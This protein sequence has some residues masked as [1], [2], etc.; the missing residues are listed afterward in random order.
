MLLFNPKI[1][2]WDAGFQLSFLS[3]IG[4]IYLS[5]LI[6]KD[7][8]WL[9]EFFSLRDNLVS[10]ISAIIITLP[11][12]LFNFG[13]LSIVAPI[14]N[15][16]ILPAIPLIMFLGFWQMFFA[17]FSVFLSG[18]MGWG[19]WLFLTYVIKVVEIFSSLSFAAVDSQIS[20]WMMFILYVLI[21]IFTIKISRKAK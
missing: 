9:P 18:I 6:K 21:I 5:P 4:L 10:T 1:L 13:R 14:V 11:L 12:I 3:T 19:S 17:T 2:F 15:V 16:L 8:Q 20:W 7:F